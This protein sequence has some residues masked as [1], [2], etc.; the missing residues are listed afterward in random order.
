MFN[1]RFNEDHQR[2][3]EEES[4]DWSVSESV[5]ERE[6][7]DSSMRAIAHMNQQRAQQQ[8][9]QEQLTREQNAREELAQIKEQLSL[10]EE[11]VSEEED[12][13]E[14]SEDEHDLYSTRT[15][16]PFLRRNNVVD[17]RSFIDNLQIHHLSYVVGYGSIVAW[18]DNCWKTVED[19]ME[20]LP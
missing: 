15:P 17:I 2:Q 6:A 20:A 11:E 10:L 19:A 14:Q 1:V 5:E 8:R 12:E 7:L 9:V 4:S 16:L 18:L 3:H 13:E